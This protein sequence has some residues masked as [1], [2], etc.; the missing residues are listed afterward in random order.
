[1]V[2]LGGG[3]TER[4]PHRYVELATD[5]YYIQDGQ[6]KESTP[7]FTVLPTGYAVAAQGQHKTVISPILNDSQGAV[8][9]Q[10]PDGKRMRST[11]WAWPC[12]TG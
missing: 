12:G 3:R 1:M 6:W 5:L 11:S 2:D 4:I 8:D 7:E 9:L 10:S